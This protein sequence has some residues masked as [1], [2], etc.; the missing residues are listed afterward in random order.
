MNSL[1]ME[2]MPDGRNAGKPVTT[3]LKELTWEI[4]Y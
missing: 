4:F 1:F 3:F 2:R